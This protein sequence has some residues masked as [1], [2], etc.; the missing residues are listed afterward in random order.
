MAWCRS[1]SSRLWEGKIWSTSLPSITS[2]SNA[3]L[4]D[5]ACSAGAEVDGVVVVV[6]VVVAGAVII[7]VSDEA[8]TVVATVSTVTLGGSILGNLLRP[9]LQGLTLKQWKKRRGEGE[10]GERERDTWFTELIE[11]GW[12]YC[13]IKKEW[14][15]KVVDA[16]GAFPHTQHNNNN[17]GL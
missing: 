17:N 10:E 9:N 4:N 8:T 5:S 16:G 1:S 3:I 6:V 2:P 13:R 14:S 11:E 12:C 7:S 15:T